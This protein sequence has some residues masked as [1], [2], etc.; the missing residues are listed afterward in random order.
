MIDFVS[1]HP[2]AHPQTVACARLIAAVI[3]QAIEDASKSQKTREDRVDAEAATEWLFNPSTTF[4]KYAYLIGA[5]AQAMREAMLEPH[6]QF[7]IEPTHNKFDEG[8]RRRLRQNH[9]AWVKRKEME[10]KILEQNA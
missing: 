1:T 6:K 4:T 10:K 9:V 3:A 2:S 8:K 5:N 7:S